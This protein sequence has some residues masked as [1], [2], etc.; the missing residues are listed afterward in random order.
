MEIVKAPEDSQPYKQ[1]NCLGEFEE[2]FI[3]N[4]LD[5]VD[6]DFY[7]SMPPMLYL[8]SYPAGTLYRCEQRQEGEHNHICL[9]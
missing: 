7:L 5:T 1:E 8:N 6:I 4:L 9:V 2:K 3:T